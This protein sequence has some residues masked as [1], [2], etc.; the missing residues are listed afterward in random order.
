MEDYRVIQVRK[1]NKIKFVLYV[2]WDNVFLV[3]CGGGEEQGGNGVV[4]IF[5][6][7]VGFLSFCYVYMEV[8][9]VFY[10]I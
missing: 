4:W 9:G 7:F 5:Q 8:E 1:S 6:G 2:Y 3:Y 10:C